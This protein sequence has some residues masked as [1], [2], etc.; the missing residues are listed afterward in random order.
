MQ[1]LYL[2]ISINEKHDKTLKIAGLNYPEEREKYY[3]TKVNWGQH[4]TAATGHYTPDV[5]MYKYLVKSD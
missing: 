3:N 2:K 1:N 5:L 4:I